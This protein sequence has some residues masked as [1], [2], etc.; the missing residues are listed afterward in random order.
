[1][2]LYKQLHKLYLHHT[3]IYLI[4]LLD[5]KAV[6]ITIQWQGETGSVSEV[7]VDAANPSH[8]LVSIDPKYFRPTEVDILLGNPAKAKA[9]LGWAPT[10]LFHDLVNEMVAHDLAEVDNGCIERD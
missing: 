6:D 4:F 1:M 10:T 7:G 8:V 9:K 2:Q 3:V 5:I